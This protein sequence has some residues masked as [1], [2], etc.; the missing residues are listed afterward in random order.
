VTDVLAD[1]PGQTEALYVEKLLRLPDLGWVYG[2]PTDAP[3][4]NSL[5]AARGRAFTFGCLNHPGKLSEPCLDAWGAI[6]KSVPKSRLVLLAG[7]SVES[8]NALAARFTS[9]GV[10]SDRL[11]LVYRLPVNDYF[12]AYQPLDLALDPFPYN[13]GVTTCD[14]LW[15]GVPVLSVT[16]RDARG[17]QGT[18]LLN[19]IGLPEFIADTPEQLVSL[20]AKWA[21]QPESLAELRGTVGE[22]MQQSPITDAATYV[23]HLEAAY[24][25]A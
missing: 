9:R 4:P 22:M 6:L 5:P 18:S 15:M 13:G 23:K 25:S 3:V 10:A 1:P 17:R 11:E 20:A 12:E 16:G 14:A 2:P 8:A 7:D 21:E 19:A 24:R